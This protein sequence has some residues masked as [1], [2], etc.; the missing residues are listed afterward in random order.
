M[1]TAWDEHKSV[2][3]RLADYCR[4]KADASEESAETTS[5]PLTWNERINLMTVEEK[6]QWMRNEGML[7]H[8]QC[9]NDAWEHV[10]NKRGCYSEKYDELMTERLN[11]PCEGGE[12]E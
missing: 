10:L 4:I 3:G 9:A 12:K 1:K 11:S 5:T 7:M 2:Y 8:N 6:A